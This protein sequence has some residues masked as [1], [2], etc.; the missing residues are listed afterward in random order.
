MPSGLVW[1]Q[2]ALVPGLIALSA[3][4]VAAEYAVL[5]IR[6]TRIEELVRQGRSGSRLLARL[7]SDLNGSLATIQICI[8]ACG[9]LLGAAGESIL[10]DP[11]E[12]LL[13]PIGLALPPK[14]SHTVAFVL[15]FAAV[16]FFTVVLSELLPKALTLKY[17]ERVALFV[18]RPIAVLRLVCAPLVFLMNR[19]ANGISHLFGLG[20]VRFEEPIHSE[21]ELEMLVDRADDAGEFH[22]EHGDLLRRAFDFADLKVR[23]VMI[24]MH[25]VGVLDSNMTADEL[26]GRLSELPFT[27]WPLRD[28]ASARINGIVNIKL[29]LHAVALSAGNAVIL[30]DLAMAPIYF[31]PDMPLIDALGELRETKRHMAVVRRRDGAEIGVVTLEDIL[32]VLVGEI[33]RETRSIAGGSLASA[34][35]SAPKQPPQGEST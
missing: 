29:V 13:K 14:V 32:S 3:F 35:P 12:W 24:P 11:L 1:L 10:I 7:K 15:A 9:L 31:D 18:A 8:T 26:A 2:Y 25:R 19:F 33:P 30:L 17:T 28:P 22:E 20:D 23:N 4:F 21:D 16:T 5:A 27:R 6:S 34:P